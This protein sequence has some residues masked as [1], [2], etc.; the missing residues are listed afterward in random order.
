MEKPNSLRAAIVAMVPELARSPDRFVMFV[1][2]GSIHA[3]RADDPSF[4]QRYTLTGIITQFG[5]H[6]AVVWLA[7]NGWLRANQPDLLN[8]NSASYKFEADILSDELVDLEFQLDLTENILVTPRAEGG[9]ELTSPADPVPMLD[10]DVALAEPPSLLKQLWWRGE[11][12]LP[13]P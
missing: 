4:A 6:P 3:V 9:F 2:A 1:R 12:L 5:G 7:I 8:V 13:D 10:D 11:R